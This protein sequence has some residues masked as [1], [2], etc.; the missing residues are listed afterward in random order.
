M[1]SLHEDIFVQNYPRLQRG[2]EGITRHTSKLS[3][4][5]FRPWVIN[6]VIDI[7]TESEF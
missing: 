6:K 5:L 7:D 3:N 4:S 1:I 2:G